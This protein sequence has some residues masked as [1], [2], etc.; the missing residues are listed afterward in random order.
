[1]SLHAQHALPPFLTADGADLALDGHNLAGLAREHG[2]P[3]FVFSGRRLEHNAR[4]MLAAAKGGHPRARIFFA[5]KA[6]SNLHVIKLFRREGLNIE[7]NSGGEMWKALSAGYRPDEIVFNGVAKSVPEIEQA[8]S[9]GIQAINVDS[10]FELS[11]I[12]EVATRLRTTARVSLRV[13]PG[14]GGGAT[15]GIQTGSE[16]SKFGMGQA[17]L[18]DALEIARAHPTAI[19]VAGMHLHIGSQVLD[20]PDF[21]DSVSFTARQAQEI[22]ASLGRPLRH[23]NLGGG[24]PINYVHRRSGAN[25]GRDFDYTA[26]SAAEPAADML[27]KVAAAASK[28]LDR[29]AEIFFEPGR[30]M[31]ADCGLLLS[32]V[33]NKKQR[34]PMPWLYLDAGY[35]LLI[36][37]AAVRWYYHMVNASRM[38]AAPDGEF[39][40]VGPLCD[41]ADCFFDVEGEYLW[42]DLQAKLNGVAGVTPEL[43]AELKAKVVRLPA[44]RSLPA[45]TRPGDLVALLDTGA[46]SLEEMFQYCG[47]QRAKAVMIG[48]DDALVTLRERDRVEDL[49]DAAERMA[50]VG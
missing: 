24:Y 18:R 32:C 3:L 11:R 27:E 12:A 5:S 36:D 14:I 29:Q 7:V 23:L 46:Y 38:D 33:E 17:E 50:A 26:Y 13:V 1:M 47:R 35:N 45:S 34:G 9:L 48:T 4:S 6:C 44:T 22:A 40:V 25:A 21:L 49:V 37:A 42:A 31:V 28:A 15:A 30:A 41:S 39:R 10:A 16:K 43:L 19:D 8:V 2:T 20:L